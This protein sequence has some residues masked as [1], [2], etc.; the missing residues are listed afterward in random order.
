MKPST[1]TIIKAALGLATAT[2]LTAGGSA[3]GART[4][5]QE[6]GDQLGTLIQKVDAQGERLSTIEGYLKGLA[7]AQKRAR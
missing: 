3:Y 2:V 6:H 4:A 7:E 5:H 1:A